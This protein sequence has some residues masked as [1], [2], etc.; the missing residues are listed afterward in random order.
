MLRLGCLDSPVTVDRQWHIWRSDGAS[1][2]DPSVAHP[3]LA[4]GFPPA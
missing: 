2:Y 1:W 3:E 4:E